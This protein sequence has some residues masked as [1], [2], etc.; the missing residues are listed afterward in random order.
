VRIHSAHVPQI[1]FLDLDIKITPDG[2]QTTIYKK[3]MNLYLL[4][5]SAHLP[6]VL[7]GLIIGM[8]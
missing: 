7:H 6:G 2:I 3:K 8:V 5:H 4:Q 1:N